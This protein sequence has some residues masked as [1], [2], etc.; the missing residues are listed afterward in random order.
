MNETN[1]NIGTSS[2]E[3]KGDTA[4]QAA[5]AAAKPTKDRA[6]AAGKAP[7][8]KQATPAPQAPARRVN[9]QGQ[10][11][12]ITFATAARICPNEAVA[13]KI[14][15][16]YGLDPVDYHVIREA[17]EEQLVR[18][19][20]VLTDNLGERSDKPL[21]MHMQRIVDSFVRSAHGAGTFYDG[22]AAIAR[23][24]TS[25]IGNEDRD[26]D[27]FGVD[28][29]ENK[30]QRACG[31]A[32]VVGL[33]AY[34]ILAAAEGAVDAF[35]HVCGHDWKPFEGTAGSA[36]SQQAISVQASAFSRD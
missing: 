15:T 25:A 35:A 36:V 11:T 31:F 28:G 27:Q 16:L 22:K 20:Q 33:Q 24:L 4:I 8:K 3:D 14:A 29:G 12:V 17:T 26:E 32:A 5:M 13:T 21:E 34:A 9:L 1:N 18:S 23:R 19:A 6:K 30:A 2:T 7:P 10:R